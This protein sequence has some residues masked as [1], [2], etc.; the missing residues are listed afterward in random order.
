MFGRAFLSQPDVRDKVQEKPSDPTKLMSGSTMIYRF[1]TI[2]AAWARIK[3]DPYWINGVW[4]T[5]R[6]IVRELAE[7]P[8]DETARF[9]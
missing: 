8:G 3:A 7:G 5:D 4:D 6:V 1:P 9:V 2:D